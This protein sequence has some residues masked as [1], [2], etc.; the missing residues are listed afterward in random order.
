VQRNEQIPV[1]RHRLAD[2]HSYDVTA[3]ELN[4]IESEAMA[5]GTDLNFAL[6]SAS[7]FVSFLLTITTTKI[8][9]DR[10]FSSYV[11]VVIVFA[12]SALFFGNKYRLGSKRGVAVFQRIRSR[13]VGPL[14]QQGQE[15]NLSDIDQLQAQEPGAP[16]V[17]P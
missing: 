8:E 16:E 3:D 11:A 17:R 6:V 2:V 4:Q 12:I 9:S 14:G 7:L 15:L 10:L 5:V 1:L 13:E